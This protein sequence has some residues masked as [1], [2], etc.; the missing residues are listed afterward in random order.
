MTTIVVFIMFNTA[1]PCRVICGYDPGEDFS[2]SS[3]LAQSP[4][5]I[6][7]SHA[8]HQVTSVDGM[9]WSSGSEDRGTGDTC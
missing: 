3:L 5:A 4:L 9:W 8:S 7:S 2:L 1:Q 6:L